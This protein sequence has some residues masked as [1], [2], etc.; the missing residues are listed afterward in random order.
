MIKHDDKDNLRER[1][2]LIAKV[3]ASHCR[4]V[5]VASLIYPQSR[6]ESNGLIHVASA[7]L[8]FSTLIQ[9]RIECHPY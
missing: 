7:Q 1:K 8:I 4:E 3:I 2:G 5:K 6:A 9:F